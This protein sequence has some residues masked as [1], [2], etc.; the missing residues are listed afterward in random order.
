MNERIEL[1]RTRDMGE[2]LNTTFFFLKQNARPLG[3]SLLVVV[4]PLMVLASVT[5]ALMQAQVFSLGEGE[6]PADDTFGLL[7]LQYV[8]T[9]VFGVAGM[10]L[11]LAV[12]LGFVNRYRQHG[13]EGLDGRAVWREARRQ[14]A[15]LLGLVLLWVG[16][17][18]LALPL[19]VVPCLG[20]LAYLGGAVYVS[21]VA[22][23]AFAVRVHEGRG[24]WASLGRARR[25]VQ[26]RWWATFGVLFVAAVAYGVLASVFSLPSIVVMSVAM[27]HSVDGGAAVS[28]WM[29]GLLMVFGAV[30]GLAGALLYSIPIVALSLQYFSLV[31]EKERAGLFERVARLA[32]EA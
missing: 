14:V 30:S 5:S 3:R 13:P 10:V 20:A 6:V 29:Q 23:L 25:L 9:L 2:V 32:E 4:A 28:G 21:V 22:S 16:A 27:F 31:E 26:D 1:R 18:V 19:V 24:V 15:G 12:G 17:L 11:A 8:L 7:A